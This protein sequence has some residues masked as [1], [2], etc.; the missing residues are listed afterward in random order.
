MVSI[1][2]WFHSCNKQISLIGIMEEV[3]TD[4]SI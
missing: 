3:Y 1:V 4:E 2:I